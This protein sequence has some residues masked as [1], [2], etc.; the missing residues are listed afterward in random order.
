MTAS[1]HSHGGWTTIAKTVAPPVLAL[2]LVGLEHAI[3]CMPKIPA[4]FAVASLLLLGS[5]F[6]AVHH[7]EMVAL[8]VGEPMGSILLALAVTAIETSLIV[9]AMVGSDTGDNSLARDTVFS[10]VLI[11][12]NGVIGLCLLVGGARYGEQGFRVHGTGRLS[13]CW[14]LSRSSRSSC[15]ISPSPGSARNILRRS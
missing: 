15:R 9:A 10:A 5:V 11:V 8:K 12:L 14:R 1:H 13:A 2:A 3:S 7:A 4:L 6:A